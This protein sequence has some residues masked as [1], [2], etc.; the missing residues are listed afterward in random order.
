MR[1]G[2]RWRVSEVAWREKAVEGFF[3]DF[4]EFYY[5]FL[6]DKG[7]ESVDK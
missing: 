3:N 7:W 1:G 6:I 4:T 5:L 2:E